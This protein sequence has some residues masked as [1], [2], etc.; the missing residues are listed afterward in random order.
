MN[1]AAG[2]MGLLALL[3][4]ALFATPPVS[5]RV[6]FYDPASGE[7]TSAAAGPSL[8]TGLTPVVT[9]GAHYVGLHYWFEG[10]H[11]ER[12]PDPAA[13]G[14]RITLHLRGNVAG[15]V[16]VWMS[17]A[18]HAGIELTSR[19]DAGP[20]GRWSGYRLAA[21]HEFVVSR[22]FVVGSPG[23]AAERVIIFLARAQ[24]EQVESMTAAREKLR[25][26]AGQKTGDGDSVLARE[27]DHTT[28]GQIGT[29]VVHL[30]GGQTGSEIVMAGQVPLVASQKAPF[31]VVGGQLAR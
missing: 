8:A 29:Y 21:D 28:P 11:G 18:S 14:S 20:D 19:T 7:A 17:D 23:E 2:P 16:T 9:G 26:I 5:A 30:T 22:E 27:V 24:S 31:D 13:A 3:L 4:A 6:L 1:H 15:F 25:R 10:S 12:F